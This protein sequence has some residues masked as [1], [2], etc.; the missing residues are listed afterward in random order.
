MT[1]D[2]KLFR[3][4]LRVVPVGGQHRREHQ[5]EE[6]DHVRQQYRQQKGSRLNR[7]GPE[8]LSRYLVLSELRELSTQLAITEAE[9]IK[10]YRF[11]AVEQ[12]RPTHLV[13][14]QIGRAHV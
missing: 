1:R 7:F 4:S 3:A 11:V 2:H 6:S 5:L 13:C 12:C 10:S 8:A 9:T 14:C